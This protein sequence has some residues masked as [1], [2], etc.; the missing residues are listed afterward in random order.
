MTCL[1]LCS[2]TPGTKHELLTWF[3]V[4]RE[5]QYRLS[6][7][8]EYNIFIL[9]SSTKLEFILEFICIPLSEEVNIDPLKCSELPSQQDE[10]EH[11]Y[12]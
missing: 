1:S 2:K 11:A 10:L 7:S 4:K 5:K 8:K 3:K 9:A 12:T 6:P